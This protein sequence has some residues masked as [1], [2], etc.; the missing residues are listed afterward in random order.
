MDMVFLKV[1]TIHGHGVC[2]GFYHTWSDMVFVKVFTI[3]GHGVGKGFYH[4]RT[5]CL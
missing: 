5:W 1:F 3:H 2:K 4:T